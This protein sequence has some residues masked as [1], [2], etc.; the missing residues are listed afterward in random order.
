MGSL[1]LTEILSRFDA[2]VKTGNDQEEVRQE[3]FF[4]FLTK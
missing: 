2:K 1:K 4:H 3:D